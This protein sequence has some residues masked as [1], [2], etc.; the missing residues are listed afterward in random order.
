MSKSWEEMV[1][2]VVVDG[3][4]GD[5]A[6]AALGWKELLKNLGEVKR[7]LET[8]VRDIGAV[9]K[10]PAYESFKA[11]IDKIAKD[12]GQIVE[13]AEKGDGI[14]DSLNTAGRFLATAQQNMP[15]PA[16]SVN[17]ILE[18]R[19]GKLNLQIGIFEAKLEP[20]FLGV[21]DPVVSL[22]DWLFDKTD[23]ARGVYDQVGNDYQDAAARMPGET[24]PRTG[25]TPTLETPEFGTGPGTGGV[26]GTPGTGGMP[27]GGPG[28]AGFNPSTVG[29]TP[30]EIGDDPGRDLPG[31]DGEDLGT[32]LAGAGPGGGGPGL[33]GGLG[34]GGLGGAGLGAG[35]A[36]VGAGGGLP[37]G[38]ALGRPVTPG[39]LPGMMGG[40]G[41][42]RGH[43]GGRRGVGALGGGHGGA[44]GMARGAG[45]MAAMGGAG[46]HGAG[47][48]A[49][50]HDRSS[51]LQ[52]DEDIWGAGGDSPPGVLR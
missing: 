41:T 43:S 37:G 12:A 47:F 34:G 30:P 10:G 7:S 36:G 16:A 18:A 42:G 39:F 25:Q 35:G 22:H 26:G 2:E 3:R 6:S 45:G 29:A 38:G 48:D 23:E 4:P 21:L 31:F 19:N 9:W 44:S 49:E 52:E 40:A 17:D 27:S 13:A 24:M 28:G 1:Q 8:N 15:V 46:G 20:N 11:H 33:G 51:W 5:V 50:K 14:V 32:A